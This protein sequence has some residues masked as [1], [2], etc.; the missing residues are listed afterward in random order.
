MVKGRERQREKGAKRET[1]RQR[2]KGVERDREAEIERQTRERE[3]LG[4]EESFL[5]SMIKIDME[6]NRTRVTI[7]MSK[8]WPVAAKYEKL[9]N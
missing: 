3:R 8:K 9:R 1:D 5:R 4:M 7:S 2:E 6:T